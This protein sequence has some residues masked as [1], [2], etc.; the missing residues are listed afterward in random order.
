[1]GGIT[2]KGF[3]VDALHKDDEVN[4]IYVEGGGYY[5]HWWLRG[6][7]FLFIFY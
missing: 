2:L 5:E 6:K 1:M 4:I 3:R 7:E